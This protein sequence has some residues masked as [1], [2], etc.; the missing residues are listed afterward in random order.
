[1]STKIRHEEEI[2]FLL[3]LRSKTQKQIDEI[4]GFLTEVN[5]IDPDYHKIYINFFEQN[6]LILE[7]LKE[8][9]EKQIILSGVDQ[10]LKK[11]SE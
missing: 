9:N 3:D 5:E 1:M 6:R 2:N 7:K 11:V 10:E 8:R 4:D